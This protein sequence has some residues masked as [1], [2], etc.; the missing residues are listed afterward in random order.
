MNGS[1]ST[2]IFVI[3]FQLFHIK[4]PMIF[5]KPQTPSPKIYP[6]Q[7]IAENYEN[8]LFSQLLSWHNNSLRPHLFFHLSSMTNNAYVHHFHG[9]FFR[10]RYSRPMC[11]LWLFASQRNLKITDKLKPAAWHYEFWRKKSRRYSHQLFPRLVI[12]HV[13]KK[14]RIASWFPHLR[15]RYFSGTKAI[16]AAADKECCFPG[17]LLGRQLLLSSNSVEEHRSGCEKKVTIAC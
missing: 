4:P 5:R 14:K 3:H 2:V 11:P 1:I 15:V 16:A 8:R 7:R 6:S 12:N 17:R 13:P 10:R 9:A